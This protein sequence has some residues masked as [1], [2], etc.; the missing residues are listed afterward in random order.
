[1][2]FAY[3][4][5]TGLLYKVNSCIITTNDIERNIPSI[6][7]YLGKIGDPETILT[8]SVW[9]PPFVTRE[10]EYARHISV[11]RINDNAEILF[12]SFNLNPMIT[13]TENETNI[14]AEVILNLGC[15]LDTQKHFLIDMIGKVKK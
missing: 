15:T 4:S 3:E 1:M 2:H 10:I 7:E 12:C 9:K 11:A 13:R 14:E 8:S 6:S 5:K